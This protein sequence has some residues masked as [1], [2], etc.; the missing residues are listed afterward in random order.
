MAKYLERS[1]ATG[2]VTEVQPVTVSAGAGDASKI[3]QLGADGTLDASVMPAGIAADSVTALS[4]GTITA[5]DLVYVETAG[6]IARASAAAAASAAMGWATTGVATG[7]SVTMQV[8]GKITG[9]SGLTPG[10]RY[11]LSETPGAITLTPVTGAGKIHQYVGRAL[12]ATVLDFE[13]DDPIV[14]AA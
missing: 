6:T 8:E 12:S 5:R 11:Y 10:A 1:A 7:V 3:V 14:L 9:L 2:R 13:P 4:N